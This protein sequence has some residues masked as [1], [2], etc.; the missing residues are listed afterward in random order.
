MSKCLILPPSLSSCLGGLPRVSADKYLSIQEENS[1]KLRRILSMLLML[2]M[3]VGMFVFPTTG[4]SAAET[5]NS[6]LPQATSGTAVT[7][8]VTQTAWL[9]TNFPGIVCFGDSLTQ[10]VDKGNGTQG[11]KSYVRHLGELINSHLVTGYDAAN[12]T[13]NMGIAGNRTQT[14]VAR[15]GAM[16]AKL[17]N[18]A[19]INSNQ[20]AQMSV[21]I[22]IDGATGNISSDSA[23]Y[24]H[25]QTIN[26]YSEKVYAGVS[27]IDS[28]T[29][30]INGIEF[31]VSD[32][33]N[34]GNLTLTRKT[35]G[36]VATFSKGTAVTVQ[37]S[38]TFKNGYIPVIFMGYNDGPEWCRNNYTEYKNYIQ[39]MI[40]AY[41]PGKTEGASGNSQKKY[42]VIVP[43][44]ADRCYIEGVSNSNF[45][46]DKATVQTY[47]QELENNLIR[48]F[49]A[50][51]VIA[52]RDFFKTY[53][54]AATG[55]SSTND[56]NRINS[57]IG[58]TPDC[59]MNPQETPGRV[60]FNDAGNK[61]LAQAVYQKLYDQ[62]AF[63]SV[64]EYLDVKNISSSQSIWKRTSGGTTGGG[65]TGGGTTV[66]GD[67]SI[68]YNYDNADT[69]GTY[70]NSVMGSVIT[71]TN[72][73]RFGEMTSTAV[74]A[75]TGT[76]GI[77]AGTDAN[78]ASLGI[79]AAHN[80]LIDKL[81]NPSTSNGYAASFIT[82]ASSVTA[83]DTSATGGQFWAND[84]TSS[85]V[86]YK[87][88]NG[89]K[90]T[91]LDATIH[92]FA[93]REN[94]AVEVYVYTKSQYDTA[95][96]GGS[97]NFTSPYSEKRSIAL[98]RANALPH[99][100]DTVTVSC[101]PTTS[102]TEL[103]VV[104]KMV[105]ENY[106]YKGIGGYDATYDL[107][108]VGVSGFKSSYV[109]SYISGV[110]IQA[111]TDKGHT[112]SLTAIAAKA[113]TCT[114][115]GNNA[116]WYCSGCSRYFSN[117]SG[118]TETTLEAVT[119]A[120]LG[121][122]YVNGTCQRCSATEPS[123]GS[124]VNKTYNDTTLPLSDIAANGALV[125][126]ALNT[127]GITYTYDANG[128][129]NGGTFSTYTLTESKIV[130]N[131]KDRIKSLLGA[132]DVK[133]IMID[134]LNV[135][136]TGSGTNYKLPSVY[137]TSVTQDPD[138]HFWASET[139]SYII[140]K[141][142]GG[143]NAIK[144]VDIS[145]TGYVR[146]KDV[147]YMKAYVLTE[148]EYNNGN[149][150]LKGECISLEGSDLT[151]VEKTAIGN[152]TPSDTTSTSVY[153]VVAMQRANFP[154]YSSIDATGLGVYGEYSDKY[155]MG[156]SGFKSAF[157]GV[158]ISG[159]SLTAN[160]EQA[161]HTH[162]LTHHAAKAATCSTEGN[163]EYYYC[164]C[165]RYFASD[166]TTEIAQ[167]SI[168]IAKNNNHSY[169]KV[170][171]VSATCSK[172]GKKEH[173]KCSA[174]GKYF[175]LTSGSYTEVTEASLVISK[176]NH[177]FGAD[178]KC[179]A[180]G[181]AASSVTTTIKKNISYTALKASSFEGNKAIATHTYKDQT[182][183]P[184]TPYYQT[185]GAG[186]RTDYA[187]AV[188]LLQAY[189]AQNVFIDVVQQQ[190]SSASS[191]VPAGAYVTPFYTGNG[192]DETF[193]NDS[194]TSFVSYEIDAGSG[195]I[196][197][198]KF[199]V[200]AFMRDK[201]N[202]QYSKLVVYVL[203][204]AEYASYKS[205]TGYTP[206]YT[207]AEAGS[208]TAAI[209][210]SDIQTFTA[211][212][213][214]SKYYVVVEMARGNTPKADAVLYDVNG[215]TDEIHYYGLSQ[216]KSYY[217]GTFMTDIS[218]EASISV[219]DTDCDHVVLN[220]HPAVAAT[221]DI[222]GSYEYYQCDACGL[223]FADSSAQT[224]I[225]TILIPAL[226]HQL[227]TYSWSKDFHW[228]IC[229]RC[230][231]KS[232]SLSH[233]IANNGKCNICGYDTNCKHVTEAGVE[234]WIRGLDVRTCTRDGKEIYDYCPLCFKV[235]VPNGN[236]GYTEK[237]ISQLQSAT[238]IGHEY[239][240]GKCTK[241]GAVDYA[242]TGQSHGD[243]T[244]TKTDA[245][246]KPSGRRIY[247][248]YEPHLYNGG[249]KSGGYPQNSFNAETFA[250]LNIT[251]GPMDL[252]SKTLYRVTGRA[253]ESD[254]ATNAYFTPTATTVETAT[255]SSTDQVKIHSA[256][257]MFMEG[258]IPGED[259]G[260]NYI[261]TTSAQAW[262]S[263]DST[264]NN[265]ITTTLFDDATWADSQIAYVTFE[266]DNGIEPIE[267]LYF[268]PYGCGGLS[269]GRVEIGF[270]VTKDPISAT[271]VEPGGNIFASSD[272]NFTDDDFAVIASSNNNGSEFSSEIYAQYQTLHNT[273]LPNT[274]YTESVQLE[275]ISD[276]Q[277]RIM[278]Y[279]KYK[280]AD[281]HYPVVNND[282]S[283]FE[284]YGYNDNT[285]LDMDLTAAV[286]AMKD[287]SGKNPTKVY[288]TLVTLVRGPD[289]IA[290]D[291]T[292]LS[293]YQAGN[294]IRFTGFEIN[295]PE[296]IMIATQ[297][298]SASYIGRN[299]AIQESLVMNYYYTVA[300]LQH[301]DMVKGIG[302]S[303]WIYKMTVG[304]GAD[305]RVVTIDKLNPI[306]E[307][308]VDDWK[309]LGSS[310]DGKFKI[311][312]KD[313]MPDGTG[314][315][316]N[317]VMKFSVPVM[318]YE[319]NQ[320]I[321]LEIG[322]MV[323]GQYVAK[324]TQENDAITKYLSE[325][326]AAY[327]VQ[328]T[329]SNIN[330]TYIENI[331]DVITTLLD[332]GSAAQEFRAWYL[333]NN[334]IE[335]T[336]EQL[337]NG[338]KYSFNINNVTPTSDALSL[339]NA[340]NDAQG[341]VK[342]AAANI[343]QYESV[344]LR[345]C[346]AYM[347][348]LDKRTNYRVDVLYNETVGADE[349]A[350]KYHYSTSQE[351]LDNCNIA[352][353][354]HAIL[355]GT[356]FPTRDEVPPNVGEQNRKYLWY[357]YV[358]VDAKDMDQEVSIQVFDSSNKQIVQK[359]YRVSTYTASMFNTAQKYIDLDR[360]MVRYMKLKKLCQATY[361]YG[362]AAK[363]YAEHIKAG[364]SN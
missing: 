65:T 245:Y 57:G 48:D 66:N 360:E 154:A 193:W 189:E 96:S 42:V 43:H 226:G 10:G 40:D 229:S 323:N 248:Y 93:R 86:V 313:N 200:T 231:Y 148:S 5:A 4:V 356:V 342:F 170:E 24:M 269:N 53:G 204:E 60:H 47:I 69:S 11:I 309:E 210:T 97:V 257:H 216:L 211:D 166:R 335:L 343:V 270:M 129:I 289:S 279:S 50:D 268:S 98:N 322:Q 274:K 118:T 44:F 141:L 68:I 329:D 171:A 2:S 133:N 180:C 317:W 177:T 282:G 347:E 209:T 122:N 163:I 225:D 75:Y 296:A 56:A 38:E 252:M 318:A 29:V 346:L 302:S 344:Q 338:G 220:R 249:E 159:I 241:C 94:Q 20:G 350:N 256:Y 126:D 290:S 90:I 307:G 192:T 327:T 35:A 136:S 81:I 175:T 27:G 275:S 235:R 6:L 138:G 234:A 357:Y 258:K 237:D 242:Y 111:M 33:N 64:I 280:S 304:T 250:A 89:Q 179:T 337:A 84:P 174:C 78:L 300:D 36:S 213:N 284:F 336:G 54:N 114:A 320:P 319:L 161:A 312:Y 30:F 276:Q 100:Q 14:I 205:G 182:A 104:V 22:K 195:K 254:L 265:K 144:S 32:R 311:Y 162:T 186:M 228:Q 76:K 23:G 137:V 286:A 8:N 285:R 277:S 305:A 333:D 106:G 184:V 206:A 188:A 187:A 115:A 238:A 135:R 244:I 364:F 219:A 208:A 264:K 246:I 345:L 143:T 15:S 3:L 124:S 109:G 91:K 88:S 58:T 74:S 169:S 168:G 18:Q 332:Y 165:G 176:A 16:T 119:V 297:S 117:S 158:Y 299:V 51:H 298:N 212:G 113:A 240:N 116:Y 314:A 37:Y 101:T 155:A 21:N 142:S 354:T 125:S 63:D 152:L 107:N 293:G 325:V 330:K 214:A 271:G 321:G 131:Q 308:N 28:P 1:M 203:T 255:P 105:R 353:H 221:C 222:P 110:N 260:M 25:W 9:N 306:G 273:I 363:Q 251:S 341:R 45:P 112:H 263:G 361:L 61:L 185:Y 197:E 67:I 340:Y 121:H 243:F 247:N 79:F 239:Q 227:G 194:K 288:L 17:V 223:K 283:Y 267:Q 358:P 164:A 149:F 132:Y 99:N 156:Y 108:Y 102:E 217:V 146:E 31:S 172:E 181:Y 253:T 303:D 183:F 127:A 92:G 52:V 349:V 59:L 7:P 34:N 41:N 334:K 359:Y 145:M 153:V 139:P 167:S 150:I 316:A 151:V 130:L 128:N 82:G 190:P 207:H 202:S 266:I 178:G 49:G 191:Y 295:P 198:I 233:T 173:Y 278:I 80:V 310:H 13:V 12:K 355:E 328:N 352:D 294:T 292:T 272:R 70:G 87:V 39:A 196:D 262:N 77:V 95:T 351:A 83:A 199:S 326:K 224:P 62:G 157:A 72:A 261:T 348:G 218:I 134:G 140:Y 46:A 281:N 123:A 301:E 331:N 160:V 339:S 26:E 147:N 73:I 85:Y 259:V 230:S 19:S 362:N 55:L 287:T 103:Y 71:G 324:T 215:S 201:G 120:S 291:K 315:T 236:G 232:A